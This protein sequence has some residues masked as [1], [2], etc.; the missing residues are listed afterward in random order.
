M[1]NPLKRV[2]GLGLNGK[3]THSAGVK[4]RIERGGGQGMG[5]FREGVEG[6]K[7]FVGAT[8]RRKGR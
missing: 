4:G 3:G 8:Q 5:S 2:E 7:V 1:G 6:A